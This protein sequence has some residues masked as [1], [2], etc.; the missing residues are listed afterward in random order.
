[1]PAPLRPARQRPAR[2]HGSRPVLGT[3]LTARGQRLGL[4]CLVPPMEGRTRL[5]L[6]GF[7]FAGRCG[8]AMVHEGIEYVIRAS[9]GRNWAVLVYFPNNADGIATV[10]QFCG[11]KHAAE[12]LARRLIDNWLERQRKNPP[13]Q[14][15]RSRP[16][17]DLAPDR[18]RQYETIGLTPDKK[19]LAQKK[20]KMSGRLTPRHG[21]QASKP[22]LP[23]DFK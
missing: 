3:G 16:Y 18:A 21:A 12:G 8:N 15:A 1:M 10:S 11:T 20:S 5:I 14:I 22:G 23:D 9:L 19:N 4:L 17:A 13:A 2:L 7:E 6:C